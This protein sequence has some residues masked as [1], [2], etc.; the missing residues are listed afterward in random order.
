[1]AP[2]AWSNAAGLTK[3]TYTCGYCGKVVGP[4]LGFM[5][6]DGLSFIYV[7]PY[8]NEPTYFDNRARQIPGT[9]FG[10]DVGSLPQDIDALYKEAR[11]CISV[12][13]FT[14]SVLVSRKILMNLAVAQGAKEG[15]SFVSYVE[16]LS[17]KGYVPPNGKTWVD[18]IR[19][20][21]NEANHEIKIM[22]NTDAE[23]LIIFLE[24]LLKFI[25]E[26]PSRIPT[27]AP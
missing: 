17:Q 7:C 6:N 26:F 24:M 23:E 20:K 4:S 9:A 10:A 12:N 15:E 3:R 27:A 13:S 11:N 2:P 1:M 21:S 5:G 18:H 14:A 16:H 22:S 19:K 8:C 25:Y